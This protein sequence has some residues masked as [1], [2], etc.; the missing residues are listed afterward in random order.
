MIRD[1]IILVFITNLD[2]KNPGPS[3][4]EIKPLIN[5]N[6]KV[7]VSKYKSNNAITMS[8]K[9]RERPKMEGNII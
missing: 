7:F 4:Y 9:H 3:Q 2:S 8:P 6:G 1:L 5:G